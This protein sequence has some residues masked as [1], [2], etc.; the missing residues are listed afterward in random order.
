MF[1]KNERGYRLT[2]KNYMMVIDTNLASIAVASKEKVVKNDPHTEECI[3][4]YKFRKNC[5]IQLWSLS[6]SALDASGVLCEIDSNDT[7]GDKKIVV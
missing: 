5:N 4:P 1:A 3:C 6:V 2:S 7:Y